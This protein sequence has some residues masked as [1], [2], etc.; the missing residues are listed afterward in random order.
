MAITREVVMKIGAEATSGLRAAWGAMGSA[1]G[2]IRAGAAGVVSSFLNLKTLILTGLVAGAFYELKKVIT[3]VVG[4][5][6]K[7]EDAQKALNSALDIRN[8]NIAGMSKN[9]QA[10]AAELQKVTRYEDDEIVAVQARLVTLGVLGRDMRAATQATLDFAAATGQDLSSA[11][12]VVGGALSGGV[13]RGLNR[14]GIALDDSMSKTQKAESFLRQMNEKFGGRAQAD[15][16][17]FSGA[18]AQLGNEW[19]NLKE[20]LGNVIIKSPVVIEFFKN[21]KNYVSSFN[22]KF[23]EWGPLLRVVLGDILQRGVELMKDL[24]HWTKKWVIDLAVPLYLR[25]Q[26]TV[27]LSYVAAIRIL[28][29]ESKVAGA[30]G[31][32]MWESVARGARIAWAIMQPAVRGLTIFWELTKRGAD[33]AYAAIKPIVGPY[34]EIA[35]WITKAMGMN[36]DKLIPKNVK[37]QIKESNAEIKD[38]LGDVYDSA[39][40][41]LYSNLGKYFDDLWDGLEKQA[42]EMRAKEDAESKQNEAITENANRV[43][44]F[45]AG[46]SD[47]VTGYI[48]LLKKQREEQNRLKADE[49]DRFKELTDAYG[50]LSS[51]ERAK[52]RSVL[53]GLSQEGERGF[54]YYATMGPEARRIA[55]QSDMAKKVIQQRGYD[56]RLARA[57]GFGKLAREVLGFG[58]FDIKVQHKIEMALN[59]DSRGLAS[60]ISDKVGP[61]LLSLSQEVARRLRDELAGEGERQRA[62]YLSGAGGG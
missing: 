52:V 7:A 19:G 51:L 34:I 13:V 43:K 38:A 25:T 35:K 47:S 39:S 40:G 29:A 23:R 44:A 16:N 48:N 59:V 33:L 60:Q 27:L 9:L 21:L 1:M 18:L 49:S 26:G 28:I 56:D 61:S 45:Y 12:T 31:I 6:M 57:E 41:E 53:A 4:E 2:S 62:F 58:K 3:D 55:S 17:T 50:M 30:V 22:E 14:Y 20:E 5:A 24:Y 10:Y 46:I 37:D 54:Q 42:A 36:A 15:V 8:M 32:W 11:A